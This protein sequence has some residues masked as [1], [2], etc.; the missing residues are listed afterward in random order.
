VLTTGFDGY[1]MLTT[2]V[3]CCQSQTG[4]SIIFEHIF[5][6]L[7]LEYVLGVEH[8]EKDLEAA[9]ESAVTTSTW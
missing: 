9:T 6:H 1:T 3:V 5:Q 7:K 8:L 2:P 4:D